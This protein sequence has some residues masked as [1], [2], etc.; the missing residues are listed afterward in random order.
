VSAFLYTHHL[1]IVTLAALVGAASL[2]WLVYAVA[3]LPSERWTLDRCNRC[4][5]GVV[6]VELH[7]RRCKQAPEGLR[8]AARG[9][10]R[11]ERKW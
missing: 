8:I 6:S 2:E 11:G 7:A 3:F 9:F 5:R 1:A 4:G 10:R